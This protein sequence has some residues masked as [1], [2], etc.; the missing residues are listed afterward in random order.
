MTGLSC[1][2]TFQRESERTRKKVIHAVFCFLGSFGILRSKTLRFYCSVMNCL[3]FSFPF[4]S[5]RRWRMIQM[6]TRSSKYITSRISTPSTC[7]ARRDSMTPC[8]CLPN[9][10]QVQ[11]STEFT[12]SRPKSKL[13]EHNALF[14]LIQFTSYC[15]TTH[16]KAVPVST[17]SVYVFLQVWVKHELQIKS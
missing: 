7:S 10:A 4:F 15:W 9:S 1:N 13:S 6:E 16:W 3:S 8:R 5:P 17:W 12:L 2:Q 11:L 14:I